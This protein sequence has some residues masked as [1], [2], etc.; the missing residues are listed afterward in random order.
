MTEMRPASR[1]SRCSSVAASLEE[2]TTTTSASRA[3]ASVLRSS[4]CA[5]IPVRSTTIAARGISSVEVANRSQPIVA[6]VIHVGF[7]LWRN[8]FE[9]VRDLVICGRADER[10]ADVVLLAHCFTHLGHYSSQLSQAP[11]LRTGRRL[12]PPAL[13]VVLRRLRL[14]AIDL[15]A[16]ASAAE[17]CGLPP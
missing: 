9:S 16:G 2:A 7:T 15:T 17:R 14:D 6:D 4:P 10:H 3:S 11:E 1:R 8:A 12:T 5:E 13:V